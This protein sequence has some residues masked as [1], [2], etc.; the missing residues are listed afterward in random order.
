MN[1]RRLEEAVQRAEPWVV[2][3]ALGCTGWALLA[4]PLTCFETPE[5]R[6]TFVASGACGSGQVELVSSS[7]ASCGAAS[8]LLAPEHLRLP[9]MATPMD[10]NESWQA[11]GVVVMARDDAGA[12]TLEVYM[13]CSVARRG[14]PGV[15]G[16]LDPWDGGARDAAPPVEDAGD[17]NELLCDCTSGGALVRDVD[18]GDTGRLVDAGDVACDYVMARQ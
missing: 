6:A 17:P 14:T 2:A 8:L 9:S 1:R 16:G 3:V 15:N 12:A 13:G 18:G 4:T 5:Q 11:M 10:S 7:R